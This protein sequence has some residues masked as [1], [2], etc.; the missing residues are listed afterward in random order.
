MPYVDL[1]VSE[2]SFQFELAY[3]L[4]TMGGEGERW[5]IYAQFIRTAYTLG[6]SNPSICSAQHYILKSPKGDLFGMAIT[7]D[8]FEGSSIS[9][10][11][12]DYLGK[13]RLESDKRLLN[14]Y[15]YT[16]EKFDLEDNLDHVIGTN[17]SPIIK[18]LDVEYIKTDKPKTYQ[19]PIVKMQLRKSES[20]EK[21][22]GDYK[23]YS[24]WWEDSFIRIKGYFDDRMLFL[25]IQADNTCAWSVNEV[26]R[27]P[28]F[29]GRF[30]S[31]SSDI[32]KNVALFGGTYSP[33]SIEVTPI[34]PIKKEYFTQPGN[35]INNIIVR[36]T[37][38]NER[39]Q[40]HYL[41]SLTSGGV[42]T[43]TDEIEASLAYIVHPEHGVYGTIPNIIL[44]NQLSIL[45]GDILE[46]SSL[47]CNVIQGELHS[48][49]DNYIYT[50]INSLSPL[51]VANK[52]LGI[53]SHK[54]DY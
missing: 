6:S 45:D 12:I 4:Q 15:V 23:R 42:I 24:N 41:S 14:L 39:Y 16:L 29:F 50:K 17:D 25:T 31:F 53:I 8:I 44:T 13:E 48:H 5:E 52:E 3:L 46:V 21:F 11:E 43:A 36:N 28:L 54:K 9:L 33:Y 51:T 18:A 34:L 38:Y 32:D 40:A 10:S 1:K 19:S 30:D 47:K 20:N 22:F 35:G 49:W 26:P 2:D 37:K 27:I 7:S